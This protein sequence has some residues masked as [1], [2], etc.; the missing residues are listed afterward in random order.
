MAGGLEGSSSEKR[1]LSM[2]NQSNSAYRD[3][4]E[5]VVISIRAQPKASRDA[6]IGPIGDA[7]KVAVS[8]APEDGKANRAIEAVVAAWLGVSKSAV[9]VVSGHQSRS[10]VVRVA[11]VVADEVAARLAAAP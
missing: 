5:G 10:K 9:S 2:S 7:I 6:V 11:G 4:P 8:A 3:T 1:S